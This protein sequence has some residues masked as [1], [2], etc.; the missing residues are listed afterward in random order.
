MYRTFRSRGS[1]SL[2]WTLPL[3]QC[4]NA[5]SGRLSISTRSIGWS[6]TNQQCLSA[7]LKMLAV[8]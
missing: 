6:Y 1:V 5:N 2:K 4:E 8:P 3:I 7:T